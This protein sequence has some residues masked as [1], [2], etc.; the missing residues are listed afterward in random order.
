MGWMIPVIP[1]KSPIPKPNYRRWIILLLSM[2]TLNG[3]LGLFALN[4]TTYGDMLIY[5]ILPALF[6]W[7]CLM[8]VMINRYE[9]SIASCLACNIEKEQ[10]KKHW[11]QWSQKQLAIVGNII[12]TPDGEG[13]DSLLGP[14]EDIPAYPRKARPLSFT[15]RNSL[16]A[17]TSDIHQ[18]L[19]R[20]YPNY[21]NHLH[22]IYILLPE[23][24]EC[25][26]AKQFILLQWD[27][28]PEIARSIE[29]I[30]SLY[31]NENFDGLVLVICLQNWQGNITEK[32]SEL[33]SAQ[34]ISSYS[35][36]KRH[37]IPVI[38]GMGRIM[39]LEP[40]GLE[41]SLNSLFEYNRLNK[42]NLQ[43]VWVS[44][45]N[46]EI[47]ENIIQYATLYEWE[48][49]RRQP[50]H[51]IDYSFGPGGE[52]AFP[53]SLAILSEATRKTG[54][55]QLVIC[56]VSQQIQSKRLCLITQGHY[57]EREGT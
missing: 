18:N 39:V 42:K 6:L 53:L 50:L 26:T 37:S 49:P 25:E 8:G 33:V 52:L 17:I 54:K 35:F 56:Q 1:E 2:L 3:I 24:K 9:Q 20:Q 19:E 21:R 22:T 23:S 32:Y 57:F 27:L 44:N 4:V 7:L 51:S 41:Y 30:E 46:N 45:V 55:E 31:D 34:L 10:V 48:L 13:V 43:H 14:L 16:S 38:A 11:Q 29:C 28:V 40:E 15:F 12:Y 36:A 47:V 5:G